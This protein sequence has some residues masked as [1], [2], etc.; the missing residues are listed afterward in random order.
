MLTCESKPVAKQVGSKVIG[1][2]IIGEGC[3]AR[4]GA[5]GL[6]HPDREGGLGFSLSPAVPHGS[7]NVPSKLHGFDI[8]GLLLIMAGILA[9]CE[10]K[11]MDE[12]RF[13]M[14]MA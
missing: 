14:S 11:A 3:Q 10:K 13:Q 4:G 8:V 12:R 6:D 2:F 1:G 7:R 9:L 5:L